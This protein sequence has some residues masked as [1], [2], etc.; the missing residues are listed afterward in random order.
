[1]ASTL[2]DLADA[3]T[4]KLN[5]PGAFTPALNAT[6]VW[7]LFLELPAGSQ[8]KVSVYA[9]ADTT[10]GKADRGRWLHELVIDVAVQL[11]VD[12]GTTGVDGIVAAADAIAEYLK[13]NRPAGGDALMAATVNPYLPQPDIL[14][15]TRLFTSV[16]RFTFQQIR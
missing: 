5:T 6:R 9:V 10:V 12:D 4:T 7:Q 14:K 8:Q 11:R 16:A 13:A 2:T 15:T 1:M 3:V